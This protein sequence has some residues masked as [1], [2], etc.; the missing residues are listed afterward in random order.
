MY[1]GKDSPIRF[2]LKQ[3]RRKM[4]M[5][6]DAQYHPTIGTEKAVVDLKGGGLRTFYER[7]YTPA[8]ATLY[9]SGA[10][11]GG[12]ESVIRHL[13]S[14][15]GPA[16]T[17]YN[18]PPPSTAPPSPTTQNSEF[19]SLP[20]GHSITVV[21][22]RVAG[23]FRSPLRDKAYAFLSKQWSGIGTRSSMWVAFVGSG[24][25]DSASVFTD[26]DRHTGEVYFVVDYGDRP[27]LPDAKLR[28]QISL[29]INEHHGDEAMADF[30]GRDSLGAALLLGDVE[31]YTNEWVDQHYKVGTAQ[32]QPDL[33]YTAEEL[34]AEVSK[35]QSQTSL[36][37]LHVLN[38]A[39]GDK[40]VTTARHEE[41]VARLD[42]R[43]ASS[44]DASVKRGS[45]MRDAFSRSW[46]HLLGLTTPP[47][48]PNVESIG[49]Q[50]RFA[51]GGDYALIQMA[52]RPTALDSMRA[53]KN[54]YALSLLG[55]VLTLALDPSYYDK[56]GLAVITSGLTTTA[57][58]TRE[59]T[60]KN[61]DEPT[62]RYGAPY[63]DD[64]KEF[65]RHW[66]AE[67]GEKT[68]AKWR[69]SLVAL[70]HDCVA[71]VGEAQAVANSD[72]V[73]TAAE[74]K[75]VV[76]AFDPGDWFALHDQYW[77]SVQSAL[78]FEGVNMRQQQQPL[79]PP[80]QLA[81]R[82]PSPIA[83]A[84]EA[85]RTVEFKRGVRLNQAVVTI[86]RPAVLT[87]A[88]T[89]WAVERKLVEAVLFHSL[90]SRLLTT[91]R[92]F[93][94]DVYTASGG[95]SIGATLDCCGHDQITLKV[96]PGMIEKMKTKLRLFTSEMLQPFSEDELTAAKQIVGAGIRSGFKE[97]N[98]AAMWASHGDDFFESVDT[99][100]GRLDAITTR[101]LSEWAAQELSDIKTPW[102]TIVCCV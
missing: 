70:T 48:K 68:A 44:V 64:T 98:M 46:R 62:T 81:R 74:M 52:I 1:A 95:F 29:I 41:L 10:I 40:P 5:K 83:A 71:L 67:H 87:A 61:L 21:A 96:S 28:A 63:N 59:Q 91:M 76:D 73:L 32:A 13:F 97:N 47:T 25:A 100:V 43:A 11:D 85:D 90:G 56:H 55:Q 58:T 49:G 60:P 27:P 102:R 86:G 69:N 101:S 39:S 50:W 34:T 79:H 75:A 80:Q 37:M 66:W 31:A 3:L 4:Y 82:P 54:G 45:P 24:I 72:A 7:N 22:A 8:N 89:E 15:K 17:V 20:T 65:I 53:T 35:V 38:I 99:H 26:I 93:G 30:V 19:H 88:Q 78:F 84:P 12:T 16:A 6:M 51:V 57:V 94:G 23:A 33:A 92:E 77:G 18:P 14:T 2:A 9:V 42:T 36:D